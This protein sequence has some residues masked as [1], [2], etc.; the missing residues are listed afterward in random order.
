M[1][2]QLISTICKA[3]RADVIDMNDTPQ[4]KDDAG[5]F[6]ITNAPEE[7]LNRSTA[8]SRVGAL[9]SASG[10]F[11]SH[12]ERR[13]HLELPEAWLAQDRIDLLGHAHWHRG[14]RVE[15]KYTYFRYDSPLGSFHPSHRAKWTTHELC[16]GLVGFAWE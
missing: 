14:K 10:L 4:Q 15:P 12:F 1:G 7:E 3:S 16:H 9:A 2:K 11:L 6:D 8:A 5:P 13:H